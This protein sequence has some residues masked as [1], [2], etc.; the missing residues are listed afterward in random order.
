MGE[1]TIQASLPSRQ[2][3]PKTRRQRAEEAV[4]HLPRPRGQA[5]RSNRSKVIE[6][7]A[8]GRT[9]IVRAEGATIVLRRVPKAVQKARATRRAQRSA[10]KARRRGEA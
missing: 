6:D 9:D 1:I 7:I 2:V 10:R 8:A 5:Q 4:A 3:V